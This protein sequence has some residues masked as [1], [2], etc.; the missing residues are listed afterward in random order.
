MHIVNIHRKLAELV[1]FIAL[2]YSVRWLLNSVEVCATKI[3][4]STRRE[5]CSALN[6]YFHFSVSP[7]KTCVPIVI[8]VCDD[9]L[10]F[11]GHPSQTH[12]YRAA[13]EPLL[14]QVKPIAEH[15]S[16][17]LFSK[18]SDSPEC[19]HV[20]DNIE[21]FPAQLHRRVRQR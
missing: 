12:S 8:P 9:P 20:Q 18:L 5:I 4:L 2:S 14:P 16:N 3:S 13:G 21:T 17:D 15:T 10:R 7:K 6:K 19:H 11:L 1:F